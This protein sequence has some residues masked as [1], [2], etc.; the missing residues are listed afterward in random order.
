MEKKISSCFGADALVFIFGGVFWNDGNNKNDAG[1]RYRRFIK[2]A[3]K[4]QRL[5]K[6]VY[7]LGVGGGPVDTLWLRKKMV[8]LLNRAEAVP[9]RDQ[10]TKDIFLEY[11]VKK[12]KD[13]DSSH[14]AC[15]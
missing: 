13:S 7:V 12:R 4:Y 14:H 3:L 2:P 1:I 11:G 15:N 5:G 8:A 9:F 6:P 10:V